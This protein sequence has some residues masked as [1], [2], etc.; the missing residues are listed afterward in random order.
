[1]GVKVSALILFNKLENIY[2]I[3]GNFSWSFN[4]LGHA[5]M[6]TWLD[7]RNIATVFVDLNVTIFCCF[8]Y[9][10]LH[11]VVLFIHSNLADEMF[12]KQNDIERVP[13]ADIPTLPI[14]PGVS[15]KFMQSPGLPIFIKF[16]RFFRIFRKY[17]KNIINILF[18]AT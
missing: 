12:Y 13:V 7:N 8:F 17:H 5:S 15:R 14:L 18:L 2:S 9:S 3:C 1:M 10:C 6:I 4:I 16:S 11:L